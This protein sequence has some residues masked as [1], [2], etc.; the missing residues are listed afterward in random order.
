MFSPLSRKLARALAL[1]GLTLLTGGVG[2]A[3][4]QWYGSV[5]QLTELFKFT[6]AL[7]NMAPNLEYFRVVFTS[8]GC[9]AVMISAI[10]K[11]AKARGGEE[12]MGWVASTV[13]TIALMATAPQIGKWI[14]QAC[15]DVADKSHYTPAAAI[16]TCWNSLLVILPGDSPSQEVLQDAAKPNTPPAPTQ[17]Q[18][19]S[20]TKLAWTWMKMAWTEMSDALNQIGVAMK[21]VAVRFIVLLLLFFPAVSLI[22]GML[23]I[24]IG[25]FVREFLHQTMDV[26]LPMMI[27]LL[28]FAPMR[29]AATNY[30]VKYVS[31]AFWPIAWALGNAIA[32]SL[33]LSVMQWVV[34]NCEV[35]LDQAHKIAVSPAPEVGP[36]AAGYLIGAA[37]LMPWGYLFLIVLVITF[38]SL[39]IHASAFMAPAALTSVM[40]KGT[41]FVGAQLKQAASAAATVA[42]TV[43]TGGTALAAAPAVGASL[44]SSATTTMAS[45]ATRASTSLGGAASKLGPATLGG[46]PMGMLASAGSLAL[47]GAARA[48][49]A[50]A[51]GE[52]GVG[53]LSDAGLPGSPPAAGA[54]SMMDLAAPSGTPAGLTSGPASGGS[55]ELIRMAR[56]L[57]RSYRRTGQVVDI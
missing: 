45:L 17:K 27:G 16:T 48:V 57:P 21:A 3:A 15:D 51:R 50:L 32:C 40:T 30:I 43:A 36:A 28:S 23:L 35:V 34:Q 26:L 22:T 7:E 25:G 9:G 31:I 13:M 38:T 14:F 11:V 19:A 2:R 8:I 49:G 42:A 54:A 47:G 37:V 12:S 41:S 5:D 44:M 24:Q 46:G 6:H 29:G 55:Q 39:L 20:W 18:D 53:S 52:S 56:P 4:P 33:L 10:R 1:I